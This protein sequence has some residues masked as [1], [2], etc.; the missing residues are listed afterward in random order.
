MNVI[1]RDT[2]RDGKLIHRLD[3][4]SGSSEE[5]KNKAIT[6]RLSVCVG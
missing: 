2:I 6:Q 1:G 4:S 3:Q 5:W